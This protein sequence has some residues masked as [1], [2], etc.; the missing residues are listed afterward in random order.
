MKAKR[1]INKPLNVAA[2]PKFSFGA[3]LIIRSGV[4]GM[5]RPILIASSKVVTST[6]KS[7]RRWSFLGLHCLR[8]LSGIYSFH[9]SAAPLS[10]SIIGF[11]PNKQLTTWVNGLRYKYRMRSHAN[12]EKRRLNIFIGTYITI[13]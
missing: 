6:T 9:S 8:L 1:D 10:N 2:S 12:P 5:I 4:T 11:Q 3:T 7:I 13:F